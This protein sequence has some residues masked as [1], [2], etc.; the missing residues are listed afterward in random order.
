M[1]L[2]LT[3]DVKGSGKKGEIVDVAEGYARNFLLPKGFAVPATDGSLKDLSLQKSNLEKKKAAELAKARELHKQLDNLTLPMAVKTGE[4]GRLFGSINTKDIGDALEKHQG[5]TL[6]KRKIELK[7][8]IK[9]LG[10]HHVSIKL[11]PEVSAT[12]NINVIA[13]E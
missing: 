3:Q 9:N 8:P 10:I 5:L 6:D 4:A 12:I 1:K 7:T 2:I 11:H 13:A